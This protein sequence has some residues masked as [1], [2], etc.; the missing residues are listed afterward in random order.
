MTEAGVVLDHL[1]DLLHQVAAGTLALDAAYR[2]ACDAR[3]AELALAAE[4]ERLGAED[5]DRRDRRVH[6]EHA[7]L[8]CRLGEGGGG[9]ASLARGD[10]PEA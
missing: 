10:G 3:D 6:L 1:P 7:S 9:R 2:Q 8:G 4:E 5:A